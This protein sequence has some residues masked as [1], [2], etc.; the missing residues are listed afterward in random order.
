MALKFKLYLLYR[1]YLCDVFHGPNFPWNVG[2]QWLQ[3]ILERYQT[4]DQRNHLIHHISRHLR[5]RRHERI[6]KCQLYSDFKTFTIIFTGEFSRSEANS[7]SISHNSQNITGLNQRSHSIYGNFDVIYS[8]G[9]EIIRTV[10][11][12]KWNVFHWFFRLFL[13]F[14]CSGHN[15]K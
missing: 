11:A 6:W 14:V 7:K 2:D 3:S 9:R 8:D 12:W 13:G 10:K 1:I 5:L 4:C 15:C